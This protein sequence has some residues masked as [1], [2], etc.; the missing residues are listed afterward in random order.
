MTSWLIVI[1]IQLSLGNKATLHQ[2]DTI[3]EDVLEHRNAIADMSVLAETDMQ[4][5]QIKRADF[6]AVVAGATQ[7]DLAAR[8][9]FLSTFPMFQHLSPEEIEPICRVLVHQVFPYEQLILDQEEEVPGLY[10][11]MSG[12]VRVEKSF[13]IPKTEYRREAQG[14]VETG[15]RDIGTIHLG[16]I[17][18]GSFFGESSTNTTAAIGRSS[19]RV[20]SY[21]NPVE[22]LLLPRASRHLLDEKCLSYIKVLKTVDPSNEDLVKHRQY[23]QHWQHYK[24]DVVHLNTTAAFADKKAKLEMDKYKES[25]SLEIKPQWKPCW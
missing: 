11:I 25:V 2:G 14:W 4:V 8:R 18:P 9:A 7:T 1:T 24:D 22:T 3:N 17:Y 19:Y 13:D 21:S 12:L 15:E 23:E 16:S 5:A 6:D 20:V 10:L